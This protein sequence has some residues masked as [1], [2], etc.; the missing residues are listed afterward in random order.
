MVTT[1][2][3]VCPL[4]RQLYHDLRAI[5]ALMAVLGTHATVRE[6]YAGWMVAQQRHQGEHLSN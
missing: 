2:P 3:V 4:C 1:G 5:H 6:K